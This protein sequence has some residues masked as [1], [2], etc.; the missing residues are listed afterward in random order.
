M[1]LEGASVEL[2]SCMVQVLV[3]VRTPEPIS[4][5]PGRTHTLPTWAGMSCTSCRQVSS[6][7]SRGLRAHLGSISWTVAHPEAIFRHEINSLKS[8][9][10]APSPK[11]RPRGRNRPGAGLG[12]KFRAKRGASRPPGPQNPDL[13]CPYCSAVAQ[14]QLLRRRSDLQKRSCAIDAVCVR[15]ECSGSAPVAAVQAELSTLCS[16]VVA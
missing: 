6:E 10:V 11:P 13:K 8:E 14:L 9:A 12:T 2:W 1:V 5:R 7:L 15:P 4:R 3:P 16:L